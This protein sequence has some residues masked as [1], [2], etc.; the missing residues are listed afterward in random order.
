MSGVSSAPTAA[1][2][3][4]LIVDDEID[5]TDTYSML[6][7]L[8]GYRVVTAQHGA[9]ALVKAQQE[10]PDL[11]ISDCMMPV[12]NGLE[13]CAALRALPGGQS[14]PVILCSGAP[15]RHDL[16]QSSHNLFLRKPVFFDRLLEEIQ[17]LLPSSP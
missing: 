15:E 10:W 1:L 2:P 5:I 11:V 6:L 8:H 14:L 4:L 3:L 9:D 16:S 17:R 13:L 7:E 12:M